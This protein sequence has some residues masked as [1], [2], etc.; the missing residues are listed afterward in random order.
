MDFAALPALTTLHLGRLPELAA[1]ATIAGATSLRYLTLGGHPVT[2]RSAAYHSLAWPWVPDLLRHAPLS[3]RALHPCGDWPAAVAEAI[4]GLSQ[5]RALSLRATSLGHFAQLGGLTNAPAVQQPVEG[6][7]W[8]RLRALR[9]ACEAPL[10]E[11]SLP[12]LHAH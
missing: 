1:P 3:L 10:P 11:V 4:A 5:L 12:G 9:W 8:G 6:P 2:D 7:V